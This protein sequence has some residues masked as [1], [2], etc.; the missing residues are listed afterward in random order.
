MFLVMQLS[1]V[2]LLKAQRGTFHLVVVPLEVL[3]ILF[4]KHTDRVEDY[5]WEDFM[6]QN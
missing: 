1:W 4:I 6:G 2:A 3:G 5:T